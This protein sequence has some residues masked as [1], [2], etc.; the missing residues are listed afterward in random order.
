MK[1]MIITVALVLLFTM[2]ICFQW[3]LNS[4]NWQA[5]SGEENDISGSA[6]FLKNLG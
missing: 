1:N 4:R 6:A 2:L 3:E 5:I